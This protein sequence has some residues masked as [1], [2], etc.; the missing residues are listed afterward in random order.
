MILCKCRRKEDRS[1]TSSSLCILYQ[2]RESIES[3]TTPLPLSSFMTTLF[4]ATRFYTR[5]CFQHPRV[6]SSLS[7]TDFL[8]TSRGAFFVVNTSSSNLVSPPPIVV[9]STS[10]PLHGSKVPLLFYIWRVLFGTN[11]EK[12]HR[13][14][15]TLT[16]K[17]NSWTSPT[18][19]VDKL[20]RD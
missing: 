16:V 6:F 9:R 7:E 5:I 3:Y 8:S 10:L 12:C 17:T 18:S 4:T 1:P 20:V 13:L 14:R 15:T 19:W 2:G 11:F